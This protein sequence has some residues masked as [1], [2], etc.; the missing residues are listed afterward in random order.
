[1]QKTEIWYKA[2]GQCPTADYEIASYFLFEAGVAT[3]EELDSDNPEMTSFC[4]Y[5]NDKI[6]RD[7]I[8]A[9]FPQ[10]HFEISE[11]PAK[12]WDKWWRDRAEPVSVS[13]NLWV[14]PPWVDFNPENENA[15]VLELEAKTA[16]GTGEHETTSGTA[17]LMEEI[18][19]SGKRVLDIG[20]GTG[21][22]AM[23]ARRRHAALAVG[24]EI[25]PQAIPCIAENF[26]RNGFSSS[27]AVLGFLDV[28]AEGVYFDV[29]VC[30]MI[31]SELWPLRDD[32]E[33][34]LSENG[35][36]V[37]S[38]Q[39]VNEKDYILDWFREWNATVENEIVKG[40]W[41]SVRCRKNAV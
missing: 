20:T 9:Q 28:F 8:V 31:R 29:I 36:L 19:F 38:G 6:C 27:C 7:K 22:L 35:Q 16:F 18:D 25:D 37:I 41:W 21:I 15:V 17:T 32:I 3:L 2:Q 26:E 1:M 33:R 24:T 12:D 39:L 30:N 5:T 10:Y 23:F 14:R 34:L 13:P 4:F 11:E 40:E